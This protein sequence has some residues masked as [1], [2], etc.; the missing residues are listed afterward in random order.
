MIY[1]FR[2]MAGLLAALAGFGGALL[3]RHP[4]QHFE[5]GG[6]IFAFGLAAIFIFF[7]AYPWKWPAPGE[8]T[9]P[10]WKI[11]SLVVLFFLSFKALV[12]LL[13]ISG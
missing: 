9:M 11:I 6:L 8:K 4:L 5:V 7:A 13:I 2:Y 3:I 10:V 1:V 12:I